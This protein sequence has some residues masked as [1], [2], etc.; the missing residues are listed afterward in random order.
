MA[1][2]KERDLTSGGVA[3]VLVRLAL[4]FMLAGFL[5]TLTLTVD[6]LWVGRVGTTA[7]AALG[8]AHS[9]LMVM[10]TLL[11]GMAVGTLAGVA[12]SCG[13]R[14]LNQ[15]SRF[16]GQGIRVS[17]VCGA[18]FAGLA[19]FVPELVLRFVGA[20]VTVAGPAVAYMRIVMWGLLIHAPLFVLIFALQGAGDARSALIVSAIGPIANAIFDPIFIF[21]LEMGMP[22]AAWATV[23]AN[24]IALV[25]G[26]Q[27]LRMGRARLR[28]TRDAFAPDLAVVKRII[29]VGLPGTLEHLVRTSAGFALVTLLTPFGAGVVSAYTAGVVL[30]FATIFPGLALGQATAAVVGQNLGANRPLR[31]WRVTWIATAIYAALMLVLALCFALFAEPLIGVFD[32]NPEVMAEGARFL[33]IFVLCFPAISVA[34]I[35]SKA[36]GGAGDTK[37]PMVAAAIAHIVVQVPLVYWLAQ[38]FHTSGAYAGM[39]VAFWVHGG[40]N[41]LLFVRHYRK[42]LATAPPFGEDQTGRGGSSR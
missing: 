26:A 29:A 10:L 20:D 27:L 12:R 25:C 36:F 32:D 14:D 28:I 18:I 1:R 9:A 22:G 8:T 2:G 30:V 7:L 16:F 33:R 4:P 42:R 19:F 21:T 15:A 11:M 17:L 34:L 6:R 31:A 37:P 3:G 5:S 13:S 23:L 40:L 41:A 38:R 24:L 35:V 39:A